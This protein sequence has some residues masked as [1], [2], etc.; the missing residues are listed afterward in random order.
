MAE[1]EEVKLFKTWS[2]LFGLR[3][4]WALKLKGI[5][6]ESIDEDLSNKSESLLSYNPVHKK[7]PV[8]L[9]NG[10]SISESLVIVE[11]IDETWS[12]NP[13]SLLPADPVQRA[14]GR[15]W[16]KFGDEK[17]LPSMWKAFTKEG[18][19]HEEGLTETAENFKLL[20]QELKG[21]KF[22]RGEEIGIADIALGWIVNL[23]PVYQEILGLNVLDEERYPSLCEWMH[24]I[25]DVPAIK[26]SW[27]PHERLV[28]KWTDIRHRFLLANAATKA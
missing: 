1:T 12:R 19:E 3:A 4:V 23:V 21:K 22:F 25:S 14:A 26:E 28:T 16:A 10:R 2:S 24:R 7:V 20:E 8:L 5:P 18:K 17:V 11:Y 13:P 15:F 27:P 6:Y 9:H